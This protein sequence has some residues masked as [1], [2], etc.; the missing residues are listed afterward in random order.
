MNETVL[1][2][3]LVRDYL[4]ALDSACAGLPAAQARELREQIAAHLDEALPPGAADAEVRAE[5]TR[6]GTPGALAAEAAGPGSRPAGRRLLPGS[7][8]PHSVRLLRVCDGP[9]GQ[10]IITDLS[11]RVRVG[12]AARTE[13]LQPGLAW[14]PQDNKASDC[15]QN[16]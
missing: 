1:E 3:P 11:L 8:P 6:P 2:H 9:G 12:I 14:A 4:R 15:G 5:L 13:N 7:I 10:T 16:G